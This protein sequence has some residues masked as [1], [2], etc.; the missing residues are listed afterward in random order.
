M[1]V[2]NADASP[3]LASPPPQIQESDVPPSLDRGATLGR[4]VILGLVGRGG[5]GEVYAAYDPELD[6][7]VAVKVLRAKLSDTDKG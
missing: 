1:V 4:Y 6:R 3:R 7:R 5:M 2:R